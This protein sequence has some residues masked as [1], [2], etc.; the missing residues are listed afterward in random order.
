LIWLLLSGFQLLLF[1]AYQRLPFDRDR[2]LQWP[3]SG[4]RTQDSGLP[5]PPHFCFLLSQFLLLP[6]S[7]LDRASV[8]KRG[9]PV[10]GGAYFSLPNGPITSEF[11]DLVN[12]GSLW[13]LQDCR[14]EE[15]IS[16]RQ[17]HEVELI[18]DTGREHLAD[19]EMELIEAIYA[20]HGTKSQWELRDWCHE[21]CEEWTPL[22]EGRERISLERIARAVGK[23]DEQIA[24][25]KEEAAEYKLIQ[26]GAF[27]EVTAVPAATLHKILQGARNSRELSTANKRLIG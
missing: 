4:L 22:E 21:R 18:K 7:G 5:R 17:N 1:S 14:W 27:T 3:D 11:L 9:V 13:G 25:L 24:R 26:A 8:A 16:D 15:F 23:T 12:S 20:D 10:V 6:G 2:G 19:S